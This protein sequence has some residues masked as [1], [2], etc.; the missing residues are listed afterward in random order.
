MPEEQKQNK[1]P[2]KFLIE[3]FQKDFIIKIMKKSKI[4]TGI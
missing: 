1:S 3:V 2:K 4:R